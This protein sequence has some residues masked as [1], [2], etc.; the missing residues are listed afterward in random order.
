[1]IGGGDWAQDRILTDIVLA[2]KDLN[3]VL[4]RN[5]K[6][7][8]PWQ[9]VLEPLS[10]YLAWARN[11]FMVSRVLRKHGTLGRIRATM[12]PFKSW[13]PSLQRA[14]LSIAFYR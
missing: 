4:L 11:C 14:G 7:T 3:Q 9:H 6:A 5:P 13:L 8:R 2:A 10:G 1:M 12:Y